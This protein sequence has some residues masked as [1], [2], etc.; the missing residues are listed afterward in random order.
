MDSSIDWRFVLNGIILVGVGWARRGITAINKKLSEI[1]GSIREFETWKEGHEKTA[2]D[3]E[4]QSRKSIGN[5][6]EAIERIRKKT[7]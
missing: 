6:W 5:L 3:R 7:K 4:S 1:N 2:D